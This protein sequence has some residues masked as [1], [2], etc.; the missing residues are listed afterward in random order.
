MNIP[1]KIGA[2]LGLI[3]FTP[4]ELSSSLKYP[5]LQLPP[6][7]M[8]KHKRG[9]RPQPHFVKHDPSRRKNP[10]PGGRGHY[11]FT[12]PVAMNSHTRARREALLAAFSGGN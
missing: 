11:T 8:G 2:A 7:T 12:R 1:H 4:P 9:G 3:A 10:I 5:R 6:R